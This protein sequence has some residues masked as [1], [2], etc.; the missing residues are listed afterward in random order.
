MGRFGEVDELAGTLV[1]LCN[2]A[3]RF[4]TGVVVPAGFGAFSGV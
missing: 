3:S 4:V 2:D 1:R